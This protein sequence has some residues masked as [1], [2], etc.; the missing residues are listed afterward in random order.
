MISDPLDPE[1]HPLIREE[2]SGADSN[3]GR[4]L[5]RIGRLALLW[6]DPAYQR[7][8]LQLLAADLRLVLGWR[9]LLS[10]LFTGG[11]LYWLLRTPDV[12]ALRVYEVLSWL[13]GAAALLVAAPIYA[14]DQRQGT[15]ELLWLARGSG[16]A[17]LQARVTV[18]MIAM[19]LMVVPTVLASS[20]L[21]AG[22]LPLGATLFA[23]L[24][25]TFLIIAVMAFIGTVLPQPWAGGLLGIVLLAPALAY[26]DRWMSPL[27]PFVPP[28]LGQ[29]FA[30]SRVIAVVFAGVLL[31]RAA[32]RLRKTFGG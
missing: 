4:S 11:V 25:N 31:Y 7:G 26:A 6:R 16:G 10:V 20:G 23:L 15:F 9:A 27:N 21:L 30:V 29:S 22:A 32:L 19:A 18:L 5:R 8:A 28:S 13:F 2:E 12:S 3:L 1:A 24:A 17:L 14:N